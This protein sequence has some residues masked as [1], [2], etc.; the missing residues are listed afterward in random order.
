LIKGVIAQFFYVGARV[1]VA[2]FIIRF[3]E[4]TPPG[5]HEKA[6]AHYLQ[7]HL[8]GFMVGR[9]TGSA[10]MQKFRAPRLLRVFAGEP[11]RCAFW[12]SSSLRAPRR[13]GP[14]C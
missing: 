7:A 2:S 3:A 8:A 1:G 11:R 12:S 9:F 10:I 5:T 14:L 13:Y 4:F 6:A